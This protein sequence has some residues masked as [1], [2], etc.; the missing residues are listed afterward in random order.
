MKLLTDYS[1]YN[2]TLLGLSL[3]LNAVSQIGN[4]MRD[5]R[6]ETEIQRTRAELDAAKLRESEMESRMRQLEMNQQMQQ[7]QNQQ[8]MM[9]NK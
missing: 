5:Y 6:Q 4:D 8:M 1:S 2:V 3:G 7:F 9:Q